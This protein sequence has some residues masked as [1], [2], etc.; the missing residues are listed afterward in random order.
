MSQL[1]K[2]SACNARE[3]GS[4]LGS[5]RY[6]GEENGNPLQYSCLAN[7]MDRGAW[8]AT[9]HG[10]ART[11]HRLATKPPPYPSSSQ[12]HEIMLRFCFCSCFEYFS[13]LK[14]LSFFLYLGINHSLVHR[15]FGSDFFVFPC[16]SGGKGC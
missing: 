7:P 10:V 8:W 14:H 16:L 6:P 2:K 13:P 3:L 11:G 9:V 15:I 4:I 5:G 12:R 1:V